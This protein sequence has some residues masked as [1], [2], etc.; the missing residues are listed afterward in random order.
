MTSSDD[1]WVDLARRLRTRRVELDPR[2]KNL[3]EFS[4]ATGV[5]YKTLQRA[6]GGKHHVFGRSTLVELD[7]AYGFPPG[8]IESILVG[9][10]VPATGDAVPLSA[11]PSP[12]GD[13]ANEEWD[14]LLSGEP[15]LRDGE[16]L[17]WRRLDDQ[18]IRYVLTWYNPAVRKDEHERQ[19]IRAERDIGYVVQRF[20]DDLDAYP[21]AKILPRTN[22]PNG[23]REG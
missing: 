20:R 7:I 1:V 13:P 14:G 12:S 23:N 19:T 3:S 8:T 11:P 2:Y 18:W 9:E 4:R 10:P 21:E 6:E 22:P 5:N 16:V 15:H 17:R